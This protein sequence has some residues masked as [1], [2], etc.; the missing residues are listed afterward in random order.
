[1]NDAKQ[2]IERTGE[3]AVRGGKSIG[4]TLAKTLSKLLRSLFR[5]VRY[6]FFDPIK[7]VK[8][9]GPTKA[10]VTSPDLTKE[11]VKS[12][13][14]KAKEDG[15]HVCIQEM[16]PDNSKKNKSIHNQYKIAKFKIKQAEWEKRGQ[17]LSFSKPL[18]KYCLNQAKKYEQKS[19][20]DNQKQPELRYRLIVNESKTSFLNSCLKEIE[21]SRLKKMSEGSL[22]DINK[23]GIV[24]EKDVQKL[25]AVPMD[26]T[27]DQ[28]KLHEEY[29]SCYINS[30]QSNYC[31]QI[32]TKEEYCDQ[33]SQM[34]ENLSSHGAYVLDDNRVLVAFPAKDY[35]VYEMLRVAETPINEY[36]FKGGN[37]VKA[38]FN[39]SDLITME[40]QELDAMEKLRETYTGKDYIASHNPDGTI[41]VMVRENETQKMVEIAKKKSTTGDL[42][43][44]ALEFQK[45]DQERNKASL[46]ELA[47][48]MDGEEFEKD[49]R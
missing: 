46:D 16:T 15:V 33:R 44:E 8:K 3:A 14:L 24:D 20:V 41:Q 21:E 10:L 4:K 5:F 7:T 34:Y 11:E 38:E 35:R 47:L 45:Q 19:A 18:Q 25:E 13:I 37:D 30:Y 9:D 12:V 49:D 43:K 17:K 29:G 40:L 1:M 39:H 32:L 6:R 26:L 22:E 2:E 31:T 28:L 42:L 23:D 27:P 48:E 36:G